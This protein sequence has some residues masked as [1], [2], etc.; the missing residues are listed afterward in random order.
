MLP[1]KPKKRRRFARLNRSILGI[2]L[3]SFFSDI[4]H[5]MAT[6]A[7]P[8]LLASLGG[9]SALLGLIE[10]TADGL[11]FGKFALIFAS[12]GVYMGVWETLENNTAAIMLPPKVRG[13]GFGVLATITGLGDFLA[14]A[15]V[16]ALWVF[17]P[18]GPWDS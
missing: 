4:G 11:S 3:A 15:V 6:A 12:A 14:S 9:S 10:G 17:S 1:D 8:V 13:L 16:G 2:G 7:M 18:A 5:E